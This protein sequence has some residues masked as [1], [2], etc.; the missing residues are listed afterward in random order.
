MCVCVECLFL[1]V[2]ASRVVCGVCVTCRS[3]SSGVVPRGPVPVCQVS[4]CSRACWCAA[5]ADF[6]YITFKHTCWHKC[7][8]FFF[9][10][11]VASTSTSISRWLR[12]REA[13]DKYRES[14]RSSFF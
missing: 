6:Y 12:E 2:A 10:F 9:S 14:E 11:L 7:G 13:R 1:L 3:S 8:S 5:A 4:V